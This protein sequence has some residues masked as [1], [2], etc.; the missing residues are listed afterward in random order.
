[1]STSY[2]FKCTFCLRP[3]PILNIFAFIKKKNTKAN[4]HFDTIN[5]NYGD[6]RLCKRLWSAVC[7]MKVVYIDLAG[8][9]PCKSDD[10]D[11]RQ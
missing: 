9:I 11:A 8:V 4:K 2:C 3:I 5:V 10:G 6:R 7:K 1:M